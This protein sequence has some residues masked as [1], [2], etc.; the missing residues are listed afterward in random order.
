MINFKSWNV[1]EEDEETWVAFFPHRINYEGSDEDMPKI[2]S[3]AQIKITVQGGKTEGVGTLET[4]EALVEDIPLPVSSIEMP[5]PEVL[6]AIEVVTAEPI[7]MKTPQGEVAESEVNI[8][9]STPVGKNCS[10]LNL[11]HVFLSLL[12]NLKN[13]TEALTEVASPVMSDL[14]KGRKH[15]TDD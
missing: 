4:S 6:P 11:A 15:S 2:G 5:A 7:S 1:D 3:S 8:T 9:T 10:I 14:N 12:L 13:F